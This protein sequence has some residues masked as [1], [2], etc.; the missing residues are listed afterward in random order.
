MWHKTDPVQK[1]Y[2]PSDD[3]T[4]NAEFFQGDVN[5]HVVYNDKVSFQLD[6]SFKCFQKI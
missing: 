2:L 4:N 5:L 6:K 1:K 3:V